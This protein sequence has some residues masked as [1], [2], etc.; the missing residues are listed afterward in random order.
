MGIPNAIEFRTLHEITDHMRRGDQI[1]GSA[2]GEERARIARFSYAA[3]DSDLRIDG[4]K[5]PELP[6]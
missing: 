6:G 5:K 1:M 3:G 4:Y 2:Y